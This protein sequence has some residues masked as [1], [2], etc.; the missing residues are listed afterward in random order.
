[1]RAGTR[2][3]LAVDLNG[4]AFPLPVLAASGCLGT[5][6]DGYGLVDVRRLGGIVTRSLTL[7]PARG[8]GSP[9]MAETPSG[10][11]TSVGFQNAGVEQ[12]VREDLPRL[13]RVGTPVIVSV[14][15][16]SLEEYLRVT[17]FVHSEPGVVAIEVCLATPDLEL[18]D[19]A[20]FWARMDRTVEIVGSVARMSRLPVF[21]KLPPLLPR[22]EETA[23]SC[24]RV[25]AHGLTLIDG[26]PGMAIDPSRLR[27]WLAEGIGT[28]SGPA[29]RPIA[30]AAVHK[31]ARSLPGVPIMGVGGITSGSDAVEFLLAGAWAVQVGT[32]MLVD[33]AAP[34]EIA[35]GIL[36]HLRST[37]LAS[38]AELRS[39]LR[40]MEGGNG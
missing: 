1:M 12:F 29:I 35:Q 20:P 18:G 22:L 10:L 17:G 36:R 32:A 8:S 4:V 28:L 9:R 6:R 31:V 37:G 13:A 40:G 19:G 16:S 25:G 33:P 34:L 15:G 21:A 26:V 7:E 11:L 2:P 5:G 30:L 27:P 38:P 3:S 39:H 24:V 14:A 23:E